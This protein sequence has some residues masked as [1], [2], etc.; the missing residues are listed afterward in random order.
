MK[1]QVKLWNSHLPHFHT[2]VP[3]KSSFAKGK[4]KHKIAKESDCIT[5]QLLRFLSCKLTYTMEER[6]KRICIHVLLLWSLLFLLFHLLWF[7]CQ[8]PGPDPK[9]V[10]KISLWHYWSCNILY[11][12]PFIAA[13]CHVSL[14]HAAS[15][16]AGHFISVCFFL[17]SS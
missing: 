11:S 3:S 15:L 5:F 2:L 14:V 9:S 4:E 12:F 10:E 7:L 6:I 8:Y 13:T 1:V 16:Q 17:T